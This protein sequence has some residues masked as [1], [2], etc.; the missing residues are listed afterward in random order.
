MKSLL[1]RF[2][3]PSGSGPQPPQGGAPGSRQ[4]PP[5]LVS[6]SSSV[7]FNVDATRGDE[8][9]AP[10]DRDRASDFAP[11]PAQVSW[12]PCVFCVFACL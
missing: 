4:E 3:K 1:S 7:A 5:S 9:H 11:A 6:P 2:K 12:H 10:S 8:A